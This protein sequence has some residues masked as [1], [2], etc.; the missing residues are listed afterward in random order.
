[1]ATCLAVADAG[2]SPLRRLAEKGFDMRAYLAASMSLA[3]LLILAGCSPSG[4]SETATA[5]AT[6]AESAAPAP[7]P[8]PVLSAAALPAPYNEA[9]LDMGEQTYAMRCKAC[10][11]VDPA[12]GDMIGPNLHGVF[13]RKPGSKEGFRYSP[14]MTAFAASTP[15]ATWQPE[16][17]DKWLADPSGYLPGSAMIFNGL[18]DP[19]ERRNLIGYLLAASAS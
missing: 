12:A 5:P 17:L 10:H 11:A 6:A 4:E 7:A 3:G 19:G 2:V 18:S 14:A 8:K 1:V 9:A 16:E 15:M 13:A